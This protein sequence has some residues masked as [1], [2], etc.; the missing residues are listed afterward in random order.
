MGN[1]DNIDIIKNKQQP[2]LAF[3]CWLINKQQ[4]WV[5]PGREQAAT[6][7]NNESSLLGLLILNTLN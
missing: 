4:V 3:L 5:L 1:P 2:Y 7:G 6:D